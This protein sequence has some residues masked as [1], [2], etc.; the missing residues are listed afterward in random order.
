MTSRGPAAGDQLMMPERIGPYR[1]ERTLGRGGMGVVYAAWDERLRRRVALKRLLP[2]VVGDSRRRERVRREARSI[3][4]LDHAAIVQIYDLLETGEGD[5]IVMQY[6]DGP[7]LAERL[8][9]GPLPPAEV[10]ALARDVAGA[11]AAAHE[12]GLLHRDLKAENV[13]LTPGGG[14]KVLDFGLAKLYLPEAPDQTAGLTAGIVGT[15]RAM[16]PEQANGLEVDPRADLF[17]LGTLL[18]EAATA[19]SPFQQATPVA[20]MTRVC[21]HQQPP[22]H[23]VEPAV[24][25][26]LSE[27]I[28]SLLEKDPARRPASAASF[29]HRLEVAV[30]AGVLQ[31]AAAEAL[32]TLDPSTAPN[33]DPEPTLGSYT[34]AGRRFR[35]SL[36]S[37]ILALGA[38]A[39]AALLLRPGLP[40][41]EPHYVVVARPE[42]SAGTAAADEGPERL[43][44]AALHAALLRSLA[45]LDGVVALAA[46]PTEGSATAP[47]LAQVHAADEVLTSTL[48]CA[49][50]RCQATLRRQRGTDGQLLDVQT[51]EVPVDD[52][53]LLS[54]AAYTY[55]KAGYAGFSPRRG[56][57]ELSVRAEDYVRF[58]ELQRREEE[59]RPADL[60]P[61]LAELAKVRLGSPLFVDAYLLEARLTSRRFFETRE[62]MDL[63][64]SL[65]LI[66]QARNLAPG[67]TLT[68]VV[69]FEVA[70]GAGR[71]DTAEAAAGELER[72]VPGDAG[73]LHRRAVLSEARNEGRRA[74]ELL[75]EVVD[76][77]P[78]AGFL[79]DLA[80]ME[81]RQGE[82][83]A[84]RTTLEDLLRRIPG[85]LGGERLLAQVELQSGSPA[86]AAELYVGLLRRR[87]GFTELSNLGVARLLLGDWKGAAASLEEAYALAPKSAPAALNLADA[88]T[89][90]GRRDEASALYAHVL[91]LVAQDPAPD[92][93]QTL[94]VKAQALAHLGRAP[95]AATAVQRATADAPDN[96][97]LAYEA[98]LVYALIGDRASAQ[99]SAERA[100]S[101]GFDRRWFALPFFDSLCGIPA[102]SDLLAAAE[103]PAATPPPADR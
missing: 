49:A 93:W 27:L 91:E 96:P 75:R 55:L 29:L 17:S 42:I 85:H 9:R 51:F 18:Y 73:A 71:L 101:G 2:E 102:W 34:T 63:D 40:V 86:R 15:Y 37:G 53:R 11:L 76:R 20:T 52:A 4:R 5:W 8:R 77:R 81:L 90:A 97:Q 60:A 16:S 46:D 41:R 19:V 100:V 58:L 47:R 67:D 89:L 44:A 83:A 79:M 95:E 7:T 65:A 39:T 92:F 82:V 59:K 103:E 62:A 22:T 61:L 12:Q 69:L 78:A 54:T 6:I 28:D 45:S 64:R 23:E 50:R 32:P 35:L 87:R 57:R 3:A 56:T 21:T 38:L 31:S 84:A 72:L 68:Y 74:L 26:A 70:L 33:A 24:P 94:S 48:D 88:M 1:L 13:L 25:V 43:A 10:I 98:A 99:A 66:D 80:R 14:A 30:A 36:V